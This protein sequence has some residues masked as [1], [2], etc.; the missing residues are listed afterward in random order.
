MEIRNYWQ[1][2]SQ[3]VILVGSFS[4]LELTLMKNIYSRKISRATII[5]VST[6]QEILCVKNMIGGNDYTCLREFEEVTDLRA[7]GDNWIDDVNDSLVLLDNLPQ[8]MRFKVINDVGDSAEKRVTTL[9][10]KATTLSY[11]QI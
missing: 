8:I 6:M 3:E 2:Y 11:I 4:L 9:L 1:L 10:S 7:I 5:N